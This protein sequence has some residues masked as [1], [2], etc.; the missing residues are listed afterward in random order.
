M[1]AEGGD[2]E[3]ERL[4]EKKLKEMQEQA[5]ARRRAEELAAQRRLALKRILTPE[6]LAR[7]DNL[8][9]VRPE[10]VEA[11]EQ[12]LISLAASGRVKLPITD[13]DLKDILAQI[14]EK[15]RKEYRFR[16]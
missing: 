3:L 9:I 7:L 12:Q 14:Y 16:F 10:L 6:A 15:S 1:A 5:E 13:E 11:L 8:R 4:R 2:E